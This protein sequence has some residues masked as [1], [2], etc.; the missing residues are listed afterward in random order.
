MTTGQAIDPTIRTLRTVGPLLERLLQQVGGLRAR[1]EGP[2]S[3]AWEAPL[4]FN[5]QAFDDANDLFEVLVTTVDYEA[6]WLKVDA[7]HLP[8]TVWRNASGHVIGFRAGI[9]PTAGRK[10]A[11]VLT[12][13]LEEHL[14]QLEDHALDS[15]LWTVRG[16][17]ARY[18]YSDRVT[19]SKV[20]VCPTDRG[21]LQIQPPRWD[22]DDR[23]I[24][25]QRCGQA[26]TEAEHDLAGTRLAAVIASAKRAAKRTKITTHL[27]GL[28]G[29][30]VAAS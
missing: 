28:Y 16:K 6:A 10:A 11:T 15:L 30:M 12:L 2:A 27:E 3:T 14:E 7:P 23:R 8:R 29:G 24:S 18:P 17:A 22:G 9:T 19:L 13:W 1:P 4:P 5:G 20:A 25:C 21:A 26:F